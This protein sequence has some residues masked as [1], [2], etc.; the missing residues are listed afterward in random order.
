MFVRCIVSVGLEDFDFYTGFQ[1]ECFV[2]PEGSWSP[3]LSDRDRVHAEV[4]DLDLASHVVTDNDSQE[5]HEHSNR[6]GKEPGF[7]FHSRNMLHYIV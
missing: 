1:Y 2:E 4:G 7:W 3:V 5:E 6:D